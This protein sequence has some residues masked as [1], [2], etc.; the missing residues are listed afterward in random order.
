[1]LDKPQNIQLGDSTAAKH[2]AGGISSPLQA[3]ID[4]SKRTGVHPMAIKIGLSG[5]AWFL[6][7]MWLCFAGETEVD[8]SLAV[9]TGFF[10]MYFTLLLLTASMIVDDPRWRQRKVRFGEFLKAEVPIGD[11]TM[12]GRDVLIH[13]LLLPIT[14][15]AGGTLIGFAWLMAKAGS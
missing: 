4:S 12:T 11:G 2:D 8:L 3:Y 9:V 13:V 15:G 7:V 14:L 1:M 5:V 10:V 6:A